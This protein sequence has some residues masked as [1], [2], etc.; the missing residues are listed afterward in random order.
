MKK[1]VIMILSTLALSACSMEDVFSLMAQSEVEK[2]A[3]ESVNSSVKIVENFEQIAASKRQSAIKTAKLDST[4]GDGSFGYA[5]ITEES[6]QTKIEIIAILPPFQTETDFYQVWL[7]DSQTNVYTSVGRMIWD[8]AN[9][10]RSL[11]S[12]LPAKLSE[13]V[14]VRVSAETQ[15]GEQPSNT[16]LRGSF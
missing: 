10:S 8:E 4:T 5:F 13:S 15:P 11:E 2:S 14:E 6:G 16:V 12:K 7:H 1:L 9:S 3:S